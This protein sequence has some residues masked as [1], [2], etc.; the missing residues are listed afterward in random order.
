M[1]Q[2]VD[3]RNLPLRNFIDACAAASAAT[4]ALTS[5]DKLPMGRETVRASSSTAD[6]VGGLF[7]DTL[8][9]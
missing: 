6:G 8:N 1:N 3:E 7:S 2:S 5:L 9:Y 4:F